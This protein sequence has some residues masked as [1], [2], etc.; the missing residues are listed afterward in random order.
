MPSLKVDEISPFNRWKY[1][2]YYAAPDF[3]SSATIGT[4]IW[5]W[6]SFYAL[7][8]E[9]TFDWVYFMTVCL[10]CQAKCI[11]NKLM[12]FIREFLDHHFVGRHSQFVFAAFFGE[13][14]GFI[15]FNA[16]DEIL[17]THH[18]LVVVVKSCSLSCRSKIRE[19]IFLCHNVFS[20]FL[21]ALLNNPTFSIQKWKETNLLLQLLTFWSSEWQEIQIDIKSESP[22]MLYNGLWKRRSR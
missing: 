19:R 1:L 14:A 13:F 21:W 22:R 17:C 12:I 18:F 2:V 10:L 8:T 15:N 6:G 11:H 20:N 3:L 7:E 16:K 5:L 4:H 9:F